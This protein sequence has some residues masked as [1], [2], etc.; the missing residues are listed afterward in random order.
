MPEIGYLQVKAT[1][2]RA[3]L[4]LEDVAVSILDD[5]GKLLGLRLTDSS[6]NTRPIRLEVP[7][8]ANGQAPDPGKPVF[9]SVNLY[10]RAENY[11][12]V[13]VRHV[14]VFPQTTTV[15]QLHLVPLSRMP[16][17]WNDTELFETPAQ[18]L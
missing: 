11:T 2:S 8:F 18:N 16:G 9:A 14:Q 12:Q 4:P 17:A 13:L 6:G 1:T 5:N 15:Q 3:E 7:D 10:A